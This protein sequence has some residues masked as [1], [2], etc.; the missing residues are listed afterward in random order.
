ME[1]MK[2]FWTDTARNQLEDIF[3]YYSEKANLNTAKKLIGKIIDRTI[4]LE[5]NPLSGTKEPL[6]QQRKF[7]YR[8][9][10]EGHYK[11]IYWIDGNY[12]QVA[13]IFDCRQNPVKMKRVK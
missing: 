2:V 8:Y 4:Q 3:N 12:I 11:I 6:L 5:N 1:I 7:E 10:V 13:S 9:L